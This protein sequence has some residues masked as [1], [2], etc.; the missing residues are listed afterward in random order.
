MVVTTPLSLVDIALQFH[1]KS[2]LQQTGD[3]IQRKIAEWWCTTVISGTTAHNKFRAAI[4]GRQM[5]R[6]SARE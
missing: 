3:S 6:H 1:I 2:E 5:A 4:M